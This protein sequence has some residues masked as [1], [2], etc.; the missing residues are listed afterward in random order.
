MSVMG[1]LYACVVTVAVAVLLLGC[2]RSESR[3]QAK[4]DSRTGKR[5]AVAEPVPTRPCCTRLAVGG[6]NEAEVKDASPSPEK[7]VT[8]PVSGEA[9][10]TNVCTIHLGKCIY[11]CSKR[12]A[13][14]F[15]KE[16]EKYLKKLD[17]QG[18]VLNDASSCRHL[19]R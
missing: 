16:P 2:E 18:V 8:C 13:S 14:E 4:L 17:E 19:E 6:D 9:V 3:K 10:D 11:F 1:S 5:A 12:C 7:Q 15:A